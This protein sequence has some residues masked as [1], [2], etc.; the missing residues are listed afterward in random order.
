MTRRLLS[1][2]ALLLALAPRSGAALVN[3][4]AGARTVLGVQ[5]LQDYGDPSVYYYVPQVP[6]LATN[7]DGSFQLLFRKYVGADG[8]SSGGLFHALVEFSL[9]AEALAALEKELKKTDPG[10]RIAGPVQLMPAKEGAEDE[11][12]S[13][14][15][16]SA[17]LN[18]TDA[19][20]FARSVVTSGQ[21]PVSPGSRAA[22]AA[23]LS[24][25]GATLLWDSL[26]GSTSDVSVAIHA[27]YEA[28]VKGY[29][30]RVTADVNTVYSHF[31]RISNTQKEFTR[32]Q[33]RDVADD[34]QRNQILK[35]E[36]LDRTAGLNLKASE[37][38]GLL[39]TVIAKLTELM[40][41]KSAGWAADPQ[42]EA[43]V[44]ANQILGRQERGW[45]SSVFGGAEDTKYFTDDQ[46]VLKKRT[47]VK[48]NVFS[49]TLTKSS[50]V[51]VP[52][53]TAGN[54]GGLYKALKN[55][56]RYFAVVDMS[57][58]AFERRSIYFRLDSDYA[59][60][61]QDTFNFVTVAF[62]K[63]YRG[64]RPDFT[65]SLRFTSEDVKAGRT[66]Q[67]VVFPRLGEAGAGWTEYE[68]Q[69]RWSLRDGPV[70]RVPAGADDW[71]TSADPAIALAP[72]V[73]KRVIEYDADRQLLR[74]RGFSTAQVE[75]AVQL[76]GKLK[77]QR[78]LT[79]RA[80]DA[81]SSGRVALYHDRGT[82]MAYSVSWHSPTQTVKGERALI[83]RDYLF[84]VPPAPP[85]P[86][87]PTAPTGPGG[88][89]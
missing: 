9:P 13:F 7:G 88:V 75:L 51:K 18:R 36:A 72:P 80:R 25:E 19:N 35:I 65:R 11:K 49:M 43:A 30:A 84:V 12:G 59:D 44:E 5:L 79:L 47:D 28:A 1:L 81:D 63:R 34:L 2:T 89:P 67:E 31:S 39:N 69:V 8:A 70:L 42:R 3:L 76:A 64:D 17:T 60:A 26:Q 62:R 4:D 58:T 53:D 77:V 14:Q 61:L 83:D 74:E 16:V 85:A 23:L 66:L 40:F 46:W 52:V 20:P 86:T 6:R 71:I 78:R 82:P 37:M 50:T 54:L 87:G 41:D 29:E 45:F 73:E 21:A 55:D 38:E 32:R 22:V 10:A 57:D 68:Y 48:H 56:P 24:P 33:L 15:V 27:Y